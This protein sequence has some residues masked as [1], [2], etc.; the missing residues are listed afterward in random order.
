MLS[1][2]ISSDQEVEILI[3]FWKEQVIKHLD[4]FL[5]LSFLGDIVNLKMFSM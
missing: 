2:I 4:S 5:L 1:I 3:K